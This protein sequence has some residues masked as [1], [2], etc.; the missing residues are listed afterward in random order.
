MT[1]LLKTSLHPLCWKKID[2]QIGKYYFKTEKPKH[3]F[4]SQSVIE[5]TFRV[6]HFCY[7]ITAIY[8]HLLLTTRHFQSKQNV[9]RGIYTLILTK[10]TN[11]TSIESNRFFNFHIDG[12]K[13]EN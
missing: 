6:Q 10:E 8:T 11:R 12:W 7:F 4:F 9:T 2:L 13:L 1:P 3:N 5:L